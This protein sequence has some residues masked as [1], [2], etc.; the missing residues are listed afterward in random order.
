[1]KNI[2]LIILL[3]FTSH[4]AKSQQLS[5]NVTITP[6]QC[7]SYIPN[8]L[9]DK[10][11]GHWKWTSSNNSFEMILKKEKTYNIIEDDHSCVDYII[12]FHQYIKNGVIIENSLQ[13][14]NT[15]FS[16][17]L[18]SIFGAGVIPGDILWA[19]IDNLSTGSHVKME[20]EYIDATHIKIKSIKNYPGTKLYLP[21]ETIPSSEITLPQNIILT[22]Q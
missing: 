9:M 22:K 20:V 17:K 8:P 5:P 14:Q 2:S 3:L 21:G 13:H 15:N 4:F 10:F 16:Q 6:M 18:K 19:G 11:V 12:G 1:M 7:S